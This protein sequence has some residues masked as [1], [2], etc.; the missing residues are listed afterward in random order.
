MFFFPFVKF[1]LTIPV[2]TENDTET[3]FQIVRTSREKWLGRHLILMNGRRCLF[4][5]ECKWLCMWLSVLELDI[6]V[7]KKKNCQFQQEDSHRTLWWHQINTVHRSGK[8]SDLA[9]LPVE[10]TAPYLAQA[11][12]LQF[13][14]C[15]LIRLPSSN[16]A[17]AACFTLLWKRDSLGLFFWGGGSTVKQELSLFIT[18]P[19]SCWTLDEVKGADAPLYCNVEEFVHIHSLIDL[20]LFNHTWARSQMHVCFFVV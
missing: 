6:S 8:H 2:R 13:N 10:F 19:L 9:I 7:K 20:F 18:I 4:H 16:L 12:I 14:V 17:T 11:N 5:C 1:E 15:F 3:W